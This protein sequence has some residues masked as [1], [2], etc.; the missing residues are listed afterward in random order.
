MNGVASLSTATAPGLDKV[1]ATYIAANDIHRLEQQSRMVERYEVDGFHPGQLKAF[2]PDDDLKIRVAAIAA[3]RQYTAGIADLAAGKQ[4]TT[5]LTPK[6]LT[7]ATS[8]AKFTA[9]SVTAPGTMNGAEMNLVLV[10]MDSALR[11]LIT[12]K[13]HRNL[14]PILKAADPSIQS[15][16][17]ML[18]SDMESL[19]TQAYVQRERL[20]VKKMFAERRRYT[21]DDMIRAGVGDKPEGVVV[22]LPASLTYDSLSTRA[23]GSPPV[24]SMM[25]ELQDA[26]T[27]QMVFEHCTAFGEGRRLLTQMPTHGLYA[28]LWAHVLVK[29]QLLKTFPLPF[30]W[31][32]EEGI[33]AVTGKFLNVR[34]VEA[35]PLLKWLERKA[36]YLAACVG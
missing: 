25:N 4:V 19:R 28:Y 36:D 34:T 33:H 23:E 17:T 1:S 31:E 21:L 29:K 35:E 20:F 22:S 11:P 9:V 10:A 26:L 16:C 13:I 8:T 27:D 7:L 18:A 24:G 2:M 12:H 30:F 5:A 15:L 32:L 6:P 14:Q 3:L